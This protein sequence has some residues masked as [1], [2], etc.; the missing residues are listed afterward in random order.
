M[1][2]EILSEFNPAPPDRGAT[3]KGGTNE[4]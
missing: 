1:K 4:K 2:V 3:N